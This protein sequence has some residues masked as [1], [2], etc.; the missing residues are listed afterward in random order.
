[1]TSYI[2]FFKSE[3]WEWYLKHEEIFPNSLVEKEKEYLYLFFSSTTYYMN[4]QNF[5]M[6][7]ENWKVKSE[8][9][10]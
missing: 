1:M 8:D 3:T 10:T 5:Q 4:L 7:Y 6:L 9:N 2:S